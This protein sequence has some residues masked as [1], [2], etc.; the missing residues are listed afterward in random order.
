MCIY[1]YMA[2]RT[3]IIRPTQTNVDGDNP[4]SDGVFFGSWRMWFFPGTLAAFY[5]RACAYRIE[6]DDDGD[7][8]TSFEPWREE[9]SLVK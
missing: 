1:V 2:M 8:D 7:D 3:R 9:R 4:G 5:A 6:Y